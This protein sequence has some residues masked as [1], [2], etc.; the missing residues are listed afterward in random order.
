ML[1]LRTNRLY[2]MRLLLGLWTM[3]FVHAYFTSW[4]GPLSS[5][6]CKYCWKKCLQ[7]SLSSDL[8]PLVHMQPEKSVNFI[9]SC[10]PGNRKPF[11]TEW[12][13]YMVAFTFFMVLQ[14]L[15]LFISFCSHGHYSSYL[16]SALKVQLATLG[17][18]S[19]CCKF[20]SDQFP[21]PVYRLDDEEGTWGD[22]QI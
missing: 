20:F 7:K 5:L 17:Q 8:L 12:S 4:T 19:C 2:S 18:H 15:E 3:C 13:G 10:L 1:L 16:A 11:L 9:L 14:N 22:K 6:V 21:V